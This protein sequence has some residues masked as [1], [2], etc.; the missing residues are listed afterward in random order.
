[1]QG[2]RNSNVE[3]FEEIKNFKKF[4][5]FNWKVLLCKVKY[6]FAYCR[7]CM[8]TSW[9]FPKKNLVAKFC[10]IFYD[11]LDC[12]FGYELLLLSFN[13]QLKKKNTTAGFE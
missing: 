1:M 2:L 5:Y 13:H 11:L 6:Y 9:A 7:Y 12:Y 10:K 3:K 8:L 4:F